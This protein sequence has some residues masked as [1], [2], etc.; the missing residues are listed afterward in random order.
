MAGAQTSL[1]PAQTV[2]EATAALDFETPLN[3]G[4]ARYEDLSA[5]RGD[6]ARVHLRSRF[7]RK[8]PGRPLHVVFASHRGAGKTTELLKLAHDLEPRFHMLYL[9]ANVEMDAL[10][11]DMEDLLL[12][13]A[14]AVAE[15]MRDIAKLPLPNEVLQKVEN[16]FSERIKH[17]RAGQ[18]YVADVQSE[19]KAGGDLGFFGLSSRMTALMKVDSED[20]EE[21]K[22]VFR[23]YPGALME[24][25]NLLLT[26][27]H[28][29]LK[30]EKNRELLV[31]IDN[32]DRYNPRIID[33]LIV[34]Q[35]DRFRSLKCNVILT[36]PI[37]LLYRPGDGALTD[38]FKEEIMCSVRLRDQDRPYHDLSGPGRDLL[39]AALNRRIDLDVL[40]PD[41]AVRDRLVFASGGSIR[42]LLEL[43]ADA[44]L[45]VHKKKKTITLDSVNRAVAR[46]RSRMQDKINANHGWREALI[47][48]AQTKQISSKDECLQVLYHR[49]AFKYNGDYWYDIHPLVSEIPAF[50]SAFQTVASGINGDGA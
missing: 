3:S 25:V 21:V 32:L 19:A 42:D 36:P 38:F 27:A 9:E 13:L 49:L 15:N 46:K 29:R 35:G 11:I 47:E 44:S 40:I 22:Q 18:S 4:D 17:T 45:F 10:T 28:K 37:S 43:C 50:Q 33:E 20:R 34:K 12:V 5:A 24:S 30:A 31:V 26:E 39:L 14:R 16:W 41:H 8:Q 48:L 1:S 2:E 23:R 6:D 7:E